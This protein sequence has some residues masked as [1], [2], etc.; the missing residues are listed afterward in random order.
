ME[1]NSFVN[2]LLQ[3]WRLLLVV[4]III[5]MVSV[6]SSWGILS[7]SFSKSSSGQTTIVVT[8]Q[9]SAKSNTT[10]T[11]GTKISKF[12]AKGNYEILATSG[13]ESF[14]SVA[15]TK[16]FL[17]KTTVSG[18][19]VAEKSRQFVGENPR[20]CTYYV[21]SVL[22]SYYCNDT[23]DNVFEHVPAT[24]SLPTYIRKNTNTAVTGTVEGSA[25][26][27]DAT[28]LLIKSTVTE[29]QS[30]PVHFAYVAGDNFSLTE[31]VPLASLQATKNYQVAPFKQGFLVY[32]DS[33]D[34]F[35]YYDHS[36]G[37]P[38]NIS[39]PSASDQT[40][41]RTLLGFDS[42]TL[43]IARSD[44]SDFQNHDDPSIKIGNVKTQVD[45]YKDGAFRSVTF[46]QKLDNFFSSVSPCGNN[47]VCF[48]SNN[49]LYVYDVSGK[50][51]KLDYTVN[52][53]GQIYS[54]AGQTLLVHGNNLLNLDVAAKTG[55]IEYSFG[56]YKS[57]GLTPSTNRSFTLCVSRSDGSSSALRIDQ[58]VDDKN[59]IDKKVLGLY[60]TP[61]FK[62]VSV[63]GQ[64]I[65]IAP[66]LGQL[67][68]DKSI[69]GFNYSQSAR[70]VASSKINTVANQL[71]LQGSGFT[72]IDTAP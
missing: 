72:V 25:T 47:L 5:I 8:S 63:Y 7:I 69:G 70:S 16:G 61:G 26:V 14:F 44:K 1:S 12:V 34:N 56:N 11:N 3:H 23:F 50:D 55:Y 35:W 54:A 71:G 53:V 41:K 51:A 9:K 30:K 52:D 67:I 31:P 32:S 49:T 65:F 28:Y 43:V 42:D 10:T 66:D 20:T 21:G 57:C 68:Y 18:S 17:Q 45:I 60:T 29:D 46:S 33:N 39:I 37:N 58:S 19:L 48:V 24:S 6:L 64:Y 2:Q 27:S 22:Y 4:V 38:V 13:N 59:Q 62:S 40:L 36:F 15:N